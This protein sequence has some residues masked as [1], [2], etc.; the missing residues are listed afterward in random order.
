MVRDSGPARRTFLAWEVKGVRKRWRPALDG[1]RR[2]PRGV[3]TAG[4]SK[5][6]PRPISAA[7]TSQGQS[8]ASL[9]R[10]LGPG[11]RGSTDAR[12]RWPHVELPHSTRVTELRVGLRFGDERERAGP[13][14]WFDST[15]PR[16]MCVPD[17]LGLANMCGGGSVSGTLPPQDRMC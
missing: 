1:C 7:G 14:G 3:P 10:G 4:W 6:R 13:R 8:T 9:L 16:V 15:S 2:A 5:T 17:T 11:F 12:A